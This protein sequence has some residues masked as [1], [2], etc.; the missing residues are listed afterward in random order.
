MPCGPLFFDSPCLTSQSCHFYSPFSSRSLL[1]TQQIQLASLPRP[2]MHTHS[3]RYHGVLFT[4]MVITLSMPFL[5]SGARPPAPVQRR[6]ANLGYSIPMDGSGSMLTQAQDTYPPG[7]GEPINVIISANSDSA[8]LQNTVNNGGLINYYQSFNFSTECLGQHSGDNQGANLGDGN[9]YRMH[10]LLEC[11][12]FCLRVSVLVNQT[13]V[14]RWDYGN[15]QLGT[16][17][18]TLEGGDH[19]RYWIQNGADAN[20][21]AIFMALSYE[22]PIAAQHNIIV[23]GYNLGRDWMIGNATTQSSIIPTSKLTNSST[24]SGSTSF[25]GYTYHTTVNYVSGL[26]QNSS[27]GINHFQTVAVNDT[28]AIDGLVAVMTV[29]IT[30]RRGHIDP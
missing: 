5:V 2:T 10:V 27:V 3:S 16:C 9:G 21:G 30:T 7:L 13:A 14:I 20:S 29:K 26:L 1:N 15:V 6:Q 4:C 12:L 24:Y 19:I 11:H 25:N 23:N 28:S 22:M 18:E 8:V 17:E